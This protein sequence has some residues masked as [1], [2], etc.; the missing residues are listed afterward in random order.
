MLA[1]KHSLNLS[2]AIDNNGFDFQ[3]S[4]R[5]LTK[6]LIVYYQHNNLSLLRVAALAPSR[7]FPEATKRNCCRR[8]IYNLIREKA[9][10]LDENIAKNIFE[11]SVD[12][13]LVYKKKDFSPADLKKDLDVVFSK[14]LY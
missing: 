6:N 12:V 14:I 9:K 2:L 10:E 5:L 7:L 1:K 3:K 11:E 4:Q 13:V 8:L